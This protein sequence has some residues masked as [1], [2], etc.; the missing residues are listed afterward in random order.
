MF[1][2]SV[3]IQR[4]FAYTCRNAHNKHAMDKNYAACRTAGIL[5][6]KH[7]RVGYN[8]GP[9]GLV[10]RIRTCGSNHTVLCQLMQNLFKWMALKGLL[11]YQAY[12]GS[13]V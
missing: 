11:V 13:M 2:L 10:P 5:S 4:L 3:P 1:V 6:T 8:S 12:I 7:S 9:E